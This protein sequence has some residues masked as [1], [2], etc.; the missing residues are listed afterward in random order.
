MSKPILS[1]TTKNQA[2][3]Q[4]FI[5]ACLYVLVDNAARLSKKTG[6][7]WNCLW[8]HAPKRSP[9]INR[10]RRVLHPGPGFLSSAEKAL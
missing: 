3:Y 4:I 8:G 1:T 2:N 6:N 7:L 10:K 5:I 9:G